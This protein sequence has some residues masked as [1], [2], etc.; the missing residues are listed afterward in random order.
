MDRALARVASPKDALADA[1]EG[2][3]DTL[4]GRYGKQDLLTEIAPGLGT[5]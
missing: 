4:A 5:N 1:I 2:H 3:C